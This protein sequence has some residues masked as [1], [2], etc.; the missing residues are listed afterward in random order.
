MTQTHFGFRDVDERDKSRR[1]R[2]VFDS[3]AGK[4]DLMNDLM[5]IGS[6][7]RLEGL[8]GGLGRSAAW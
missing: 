6:A 2:A 3:V 7:P 4:Y 5:S 1:V 8:R